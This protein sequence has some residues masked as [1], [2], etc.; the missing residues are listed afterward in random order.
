MEDLFEKVLIF[1]I[2]NLTLAVTCS[3]YICIQFWLVFYLF[4]FPYCYRLITFLHGSQW[5]PDL[6]VCLY[7]ST[8]LNVF[9]LRCIPKILTL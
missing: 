7:I 5:I 4:V 2:T 6:D 3:N 9:W 8:L 1:I